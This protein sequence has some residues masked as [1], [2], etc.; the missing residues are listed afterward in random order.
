MSNVETHMSRKHISQEWEYVS[1]KNLFLGR[2]LPVNRGKATI[3]DVNN[4]DIPL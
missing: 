2:I 4:I 1:V 3:N